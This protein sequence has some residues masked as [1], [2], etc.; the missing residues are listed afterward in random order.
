MPLFPIPK[1]FGLAST[2]PQTSIC[3]FPIKWCCSI[4]LRF[5]LDPSLTTSAIPTRSIRS[6]NTAHICSSINAIY[7]TS[8]PTHFFQLFVPPNPTKYGVSSAPML[9]ILQNTH[10]SLAASPF[11]IFVLLTVRGYPPCN[12]IRTLKSQDF[13]PLLLTAAVPVPG[14]VLGR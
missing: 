1:A 5:S 11:V 7:A 13:F 14:R 9:L 12:K 8:A 4:R 6:L 2:P 10:C 3:V